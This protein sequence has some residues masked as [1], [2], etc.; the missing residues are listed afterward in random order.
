MP[1]FVPVSPAVEP[2]SSHLPRRGLRG[3]FRA[4]PGMEVTA[5]GARATT[6]QPSLRMKSL[7]QRFTSALLLQP[8]WRGATL[9]PAALLLPT[10]TRRRAPPLLPSAQTCC[11]TPPGAR[12][13]GHRHLPAAPCHW[14]GRQPGPPFLLPL[15]GAAGREGGPC[16]HPDS[17]LSLPILHLP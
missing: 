9:G 16:C 17:I 14:G 2:L 3:T 15:C 10:G 8:P 1:L 13:G 7:Q 5:G 6:P 11:S 12:R 4:G